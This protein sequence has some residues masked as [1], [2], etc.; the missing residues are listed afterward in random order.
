[1]PIGIAPTAMHRMAHDDGEVASAKGICVL[2]YF[3][4]VTHKKKQIHS[5]R[6][7]WYN[8]H[9]QHTINNVD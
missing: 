1:M 7:T 8:I 3:L 9:S 4:S 2:I 5:C 6:K